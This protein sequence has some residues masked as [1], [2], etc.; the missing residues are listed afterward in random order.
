MRFNRKIAAS[1]IALSSTSLVSSFA[2][3]LALQPRSKL[4]SSIVNNRPLTKAT[5]PLQMGILDQLF[6]GGA[7]GSKIDYSTLDYPGEELANAAKEGK[8]LINGE[9]E[10]NLA[11][12]TFAG[13][14]F[15]GLELA[16]QRV[17]GVVYTAVGYT[18][19]P[20][21]E[22]TYSQVCS[23]M[24]GHTEGVIVYYDPKECSYDD[25]LD[26]FFNRVNPTTVNGQGNDF[27]P[28]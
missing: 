7:V 24:T 6:G 18:Q 9:R 27:G 26:T 13:G 28:Q 21:T 16:Y 22:P 10:S 12:A 3:R 14:C 23:G 25:L 11:L 2:P 5:S 20:E 19:G 15:W 4:T 17:P 8:A 1:L